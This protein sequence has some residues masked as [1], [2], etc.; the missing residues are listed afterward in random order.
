MSI[1]SEKPGKRPLKAFINKPF[2]IELDRYFVRFKIRINEYLLTNCLP[3]SDLWPGGLQDIQ[4]DKYLK[5]KIRV[6][7]GHKIVQ[8]YAPSSP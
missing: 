6:D 4:R 2:R 8:H 3:L 7:A 5:D 1:Y